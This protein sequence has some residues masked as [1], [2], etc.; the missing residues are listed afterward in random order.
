M[1]PVVKDRILAYALAL[2][3][4]IAYYFL[5]QRTQSSIERKQ[6]LVERYEAEGDEQMAGHYQETAKSAERRFF[7]WLLPPLIVFSVSYYRNR[8]YANYLFFFQPHPDDL[9]LSESNR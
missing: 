3:I 1:R 9:A 8:R 5:Y 6:A 2:V 7:L 4:L